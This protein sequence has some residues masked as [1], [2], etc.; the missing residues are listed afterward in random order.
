MKRALGIT[1]TVALG[2]SVLVGLAA[3]VGKTTTRGGPMLAE[4][5]RN[6]IL[7]LSVGSEPRTLD[8]GVMEGIPEGQIAEALFEGLVISDPKDGAKQIPG[9]AES[10]EHN[11]DYSAWTFHLRTNA[12]WSNGDPVAADDFVFSVE[13]V[14]TAS[15]G[16]PFSDSFFVIKG[17]KEYLNGE[18]K[19]FDQVGVR[20]LGPQLLRF[21]LVGPD[22][23]F[24]ALLTLQPFQP[25]HAQTI[26]KFGTIGQRDTKWTVPGNFVGNGA[27]VLKSWRENDVIE[28]VKSPTY[29]DA[30]SV[31]LNGINFYSIESLDTADRAFQA[32]QLH[33]TQFVPLDKIPYYRREEPE[34]LHISPFLEVYFYHLN[35]TRKPL[36]NPKVRLALSLAVDRESLVRNVLRAA[37]QAATGFIPPGFSEYSVAHQI[38]Y[39]P[40][41]ARKFLAEAGYP[42]GRGFPKLN[43]FINTSERHRT[44][45][46]AI[47]Q[48]WRQ[49]LNI[50][51]GIENQEW[52]VYL[53][54]L[55][56]KNFDIGRRG[57]VG[58]PDPAFFLIIWTTGSSFNASG[59]ASPR[60]DAILREADRTGDFN[61]RLALF[62]E[63]EDLLLSE[64]ALI[65][66]YWYTSSHLIHPSVTGWYPNVVDD[67]PYKFIDLKSPEELSDRKFLEEPQ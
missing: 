41:R 29:W 19:D 55:S 46:E 21:D 30:G 34:I 50:D 58:I 18:I 5:N 63:A 36:D 45:A 54:T 25:V 16:S 31:K 66:I 23:Y 60:Y 6:K 48:M 40:D 28:V 52:K 38:A 7:L 17:A 59:W 37:E 53:D 47:Q 49:E 8:P 26:L 65:P 22:P 39:D 57:W 62:H 2:I 42:G 64:S 13:R 32:G 27:F 10:W 61:R 20:A 24:L 14:L 12:K 9:V 4:A 11:D 3:T 35:V 15:L 51:V 67:H 33:I 44:I 56:K 1:I 43:I